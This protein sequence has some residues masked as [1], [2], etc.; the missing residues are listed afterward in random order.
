VNRIS[1]E[2]HGEYIEMAARKR[3]LK[4][5]IGEIILR[6]PQFREYPFETNVIR[7]TNGLKR[8]NKE[9]KR[10]SKVVEACPGEESFMWCSISYI[11]D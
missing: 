1:G 3:S 2:N 10:R 7:T 4:T 11:P 9:L 5:R 6:E 8:I